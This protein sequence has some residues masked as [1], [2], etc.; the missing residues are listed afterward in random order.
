MPLVQAK[1]TN[2]GANIEVDNMKDAAICPFCGTPYVVEK[3]INNFTNTNHISAQVVNIYSGNSM[4]YIIRAGTL[5]K[6]NG[7]STTAVVPDGVTKIGDYSFSGCSGLIG[8]ILP[9]SVTEIGAFSFGGCISLTSISIPDSVKVMNH[10]SFH[11][12]PRLLTINASEDWKRKFYW[13]ADCL[14]PYA[15]PPPLPMKK[16]AG[17]YIATCVY[18]NYDCP[19]VWTLRRFRDGYLAKTWAGRCFVQFYYAISPTLVARFGTA[20][21]FRDFWKWSLD[22]LIERLKKEGMVDTPYFDKQWQY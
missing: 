4:D 16:K 17:C 18:G 22:K 21:W 1:C 9:D 10:T 5:E 12:C 15:P 2:C 7:A 3:A 14:K 19:P 20:K 11:N 6:Y 8:V 13:C